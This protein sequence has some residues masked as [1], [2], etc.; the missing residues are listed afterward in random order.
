MKK[1]LTDR[2]IRALKPANDG[3]RY[4]VKDDVVPGLGVRVTDKGAKSFVLHAHYPGSPHA[5]RRALGA[6]GDLTL[7]AARL[8]AR[9]WRAL[10]TDGKDPAEE[11]ERR[12]Q[13][14]T[15]RPASTFGVVA[16]AYIVHIEQAGQRKARQVA[17][18]IR[19][20]FVSRW[21]ALPI[22]SITS[23]DILAVIDEV[24]AR[25]ARTQA[26][27]LLGDVRQLSAGR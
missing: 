1:R 2:T 20:E 15:K 8:K 13:E 19:R 6:Y 16:E 12:R 25:G 17:R 3:E 23:D 22:G 9:T 26:H 5:T 24:K 7:E 14:A 27:H 10:I 4:I 21:A 18:E 11:A